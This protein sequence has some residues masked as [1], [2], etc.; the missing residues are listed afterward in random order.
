M[1]L[2]RKFGSCP[3]WNYFQVIICVYLMFLLYVRRIEVPTF[4]ICQTSKYTTFACCISCSVVKLRSNYHPQ[5]CHQLSCRHQTRRQTRDHHTHHLLHPPLHRLQ[6]E[7]LQTLTCMIST[8][9]SL[10]KKFPPLWRGIVPVCRQD[11]YC[12]KSLSSWLLWN[13]LDD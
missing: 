8:A 12:S 7:H 5:C 10:L 1:G 6:E 3:L 11:H 9:F 2:K 13:M 4:P